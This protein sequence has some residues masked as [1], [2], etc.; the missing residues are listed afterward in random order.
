MPHH[1]V[2]LG[3]VRETPV[4]TASV[5]KAIYQTTFRISVG[6]SITHRGATQGGGTKPK[7]HPTQTIITII[8]M[9]YDDMIRIATQE[10]EP[11]A[12]PIV[13]ENEEGPE[14][15][16]L[17]S[18]IERPH[19]PAVQIRRPTG[20]PEHDGDV[21]QDVAHG[22]PRVLHPAALRDRCPHV[23]QLERRRGSGVEELLSSS[24]SSSFSFLV[25]DPVPRP[26]LSFVIFLADRRDP[27]WGADPGRQERPARWSGGAELQICETDVL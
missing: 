10:T 20:E 22:P 27:Q 25:N 8:C 2:Q 26:L 23:R 12:V 17:G 13:A 24:S 16:A 15:G 1:A 6:N 14:H 18:P 21:P 11:E 3:I 9:I 4:P 7:T 19:D 5:S